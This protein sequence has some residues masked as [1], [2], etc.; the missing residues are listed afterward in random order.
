M[1]L[2]EALH[3]AAN[4]GSP[5]DLL[6]LLAQTQPHVRQAFARA[7]MPQLGF[8]GLLEVIRYLEKQGVKM[9]I[10]DDEGASVLHYAAL[11]GQLALIQ[12]FHQKGVGLHIRDD[13]GRTLLHSAALS[14]EPAVVQYLC[15]QGLAVNAVNLKGETPLHVAASPRSAQEYFLSAEHHQVIDYLQKQGGELEATDKAGS[16]VRA[17]LA[18]WQEKASGPF[19]WLSKK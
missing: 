11:G 18:M 8:E 3:R 17:L 12:Y 1:Q 14:G 10:V 19:M 2:P 7:Y 13:E 15:E 4:E 16:T 5:D 9:D 6:C